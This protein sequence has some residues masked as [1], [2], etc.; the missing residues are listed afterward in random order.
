M[1]RRRA[2]AGLKFCPHAG[3]VAPG[4]DSDLAAATLGQSL[5]QL[6]QGV[7]TRERDARLQA[8]LERAL[9]PL[10]AEQI[11][12]AGADQEMGKTSLKRVACLGMDGSWGV[13]S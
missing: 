11:H 13:L 2:P 7:R 12:A 10:P 4:V 9:L 3:C 8:V 5:A 1:C 6:A